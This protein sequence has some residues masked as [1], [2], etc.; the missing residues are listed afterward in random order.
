[1]EVSF[2]TRGGQVRTGTIV[3][4]NPKRA[5]V[6]CGAGAVFLVPYPALEPSPSASGGG[7]RGP[8]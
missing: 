3:R 6:D 2:R 4:M 8:A 7:A 5:R 1:M